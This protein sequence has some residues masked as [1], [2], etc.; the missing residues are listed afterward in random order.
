MFA[1][2]KST[3]RGFEDSLRLMWFKYIQQILRYALEKKWNPKN[4]VAD[5]C[6]QIVS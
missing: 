6:E 2:P 1:Y 3:S 5:S 4:K